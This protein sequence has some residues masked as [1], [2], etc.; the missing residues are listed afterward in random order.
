MK[1]RGSN[2]DRDITAALNPS[3][4]EIS[5]GETALLIGSIILAPITKPT[6]T[7]IIAVIFAK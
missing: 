4:S 2:A 1:S 6:I 5:E 3:V 7:S